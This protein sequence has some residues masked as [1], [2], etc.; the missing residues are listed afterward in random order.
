M[1]VTQVDKKTILDSQI[2]GLQSSSNI[3][4]PENIISHTATSVLLRNEL[5]MRELVYAFEEPVN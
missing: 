5:L 1:A 2:N 4:H 3:T